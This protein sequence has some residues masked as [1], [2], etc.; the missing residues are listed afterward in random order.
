MP[1]STAFN[2]IAQ[3]Q[4]KYR[5]MNQANTDV[6]R[7]NNSEMSEIACYLKAE[8]EIFAADLPMILEELQTV[9]NKMENGL[10]ERKKLMVKHYLEDTYQ[11]FKLKK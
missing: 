10:V 4:N 11:H 3:L 9:F 5:R 1:L 6:Q 8:Y 2:L 7:K